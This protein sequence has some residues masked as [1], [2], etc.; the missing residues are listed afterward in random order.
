MDVKAKRRKLERDE[1]NKKRAKYIAGLKNNILTFSNLP[2]VEVQEY[3][4]GEDI[5]FIKEMKKTLVSTKDGV[6][7]AAP[8]IGINTKAFVVRKYVNR[9]NFQIFINPEIIETSKNNVIITEGC[10]SY[11]GFNIK[12]E[13]PDAVKLKFTNENM[14]TDT[15]WF[16]GWEARIIQH[17]MDHFSKD[18][19]QIGL[20][21]EK[22]QAKQETELVKA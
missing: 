18:G 17:E 12:I 9:N 10:L 20:A 4:K 21:W 7:I 15:Q 14:Q 22:S 19:C 5:S 8:Q 3:K 2:R 1:K 6:G 16:S 11:P 13:R